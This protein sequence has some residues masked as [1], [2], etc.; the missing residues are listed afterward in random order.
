VKFVIV[1]IIKIFNIMES[2][3]VALGILGGVAAG[4]LL[5]VLFAPAK[6]KKTRRKILNKSKHYT[7]DLKD[8][9]DDLLDSV[10]EKYEDFLTE[11]K[12]MGTPKEE[13]K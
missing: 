4:A 1:L 12:G 9:F 11:V 7:E 2:G 5:G 13:V 3:K 8:K 6:G 10:S